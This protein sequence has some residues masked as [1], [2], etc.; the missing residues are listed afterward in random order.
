MQE[1]ERLKRRIERW[2]HAMDELAKRS[3]VPRSTIISIR[4]GHVPNP[5]IVTVAKIAEGLKGVK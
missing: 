5:G 4:D 1:L 2:P 3:G